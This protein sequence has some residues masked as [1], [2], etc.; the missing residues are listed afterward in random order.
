MKKCLLY[1]YEKTLSSFINSI[2]RNAAE[3]M[4]R[5]KWRE[6]RCVN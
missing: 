3:S 4:R 5:D 2:N 1:V 6:G